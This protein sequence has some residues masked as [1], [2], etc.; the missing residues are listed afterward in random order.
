M[1]DALARVFSQGPI[2]GLGRTQ[3]IMLVALAI[4]LPGLIF[5]GSQWV[6]DGQ[7]V[8]LFAS[9]TTED[10]GAIVTQLKAAR[11]PYRLGG[12]GEQILVPADKA[13]EM[14]LRMAV[15]GLPLGGGVGF[16]VFDKPAL[17]VSDFAQRLNY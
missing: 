1:A 4:L 3:Q 5:A 9:L 13:T 2:A 11:V 6:S 12:N 7:Y 8:P 14:R 15:Q 16:E 17:G 10:A